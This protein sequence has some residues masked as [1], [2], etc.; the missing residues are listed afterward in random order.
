MQANHSV[1]C[2]VI[3]RRAYKVWIA[4]V[5]WLS[6][7]FC[8]AYGASFAQLLAKNGRVQDTELSSQRF[9]KEIVYSAT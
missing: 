1:Y 2:S 3:E 5:S 6:V 4:L 8:L 7:K 9:F